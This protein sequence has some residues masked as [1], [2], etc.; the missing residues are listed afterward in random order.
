MWISNAEGFDDIERIVI[1]SKLQSFI[2]FHDG[3]VIKLKEQKDVKTAKE[4]TR[5]Q[6][7]TLENSRKKLYWEKWKMDMEL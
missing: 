4:K 5:E 6:I 7:W 2:H 3:S 1:T